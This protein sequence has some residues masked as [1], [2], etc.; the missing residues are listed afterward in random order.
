MALITPDKEAAINEALIAA[1]GDKSVAATALGMTDDE[2]TSAINR[3]RTLKTRWNV[4]QSVPSEAETIRDMGYTETQIAEAMDIEEKKF[5]AGLSAIGL[6]EKEQAL[7]LSLQAFHRDHFKSSMEMIGAGVTRV[8]M[9]YQT[10]MDEI[11]T[12]LIMVREKLSS[13]NL[14]SFQRQE[15]VTEESKLMQAYVA[16]GDQLRK[17]MEVAQRGALNMAIIRWR[18]NGG[19][20][21]AEKPGFRKTVDVEEV[22]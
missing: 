7:A 10:E 1:D 19:R 15:Y 3:T 20:G 11:R 5:R 12:R 6:N 9:I 16:V 13:T 14:S 4:N 18:T 22:D 8:S 2:L 21:F 17:I